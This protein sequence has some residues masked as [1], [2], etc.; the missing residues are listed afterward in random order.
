MDFL[1]CTFILFTTIIQDNDV[2]Y[3]AQFSFTFLSWMIWYYV[4]VV[5]W[6]S[7]YNGDICVRQNKGHAK[8]TDDGKQ[9]SC[10]GYKMREVRIMKNQ[11]KKKQQNIWFRIRNKFGR[12]ACGPAK[13][14]LEGVGGIDRILILCKSSPEFFPLVNHKIWRVISTCNN[15]G[16]FSPM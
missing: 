16:V 7:V 5:L 13:I 6:I 9:W 15:F 14:F 4:W 10:N 2:R 12:V 8:H 3:T 1:T 11:P